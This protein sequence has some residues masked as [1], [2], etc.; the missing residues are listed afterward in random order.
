MDFRSDGLAFDHHGCIGCRPAKYRQQQGGDA[1][2]HLGDVKG[3]NPDG[4]GASGYQRVFN[5]NQ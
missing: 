1:N 4:A 5:G 2:R 3:A